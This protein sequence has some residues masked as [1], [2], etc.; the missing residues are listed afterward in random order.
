MCYLQGYAFCQTCQSRLQTCHERINILNFTAK[1]TTRKHDE[2]N[3]YVYLCSTFYE[4]TMEKKKIIIACDSYKGCLTSR[5]VNEALVGVKSEERRV[6]NSTALV[7][8][9]VALEMSDGGDGMLDAFLSAMGGERVTMHAHDALMRW[10]NAEY[11]IANDTAIIEIAQTVGLA[12][13]EPE[14]RNPMKGT[15]WGVGEQIMHAYRRGIRRFIVG[16]GGSATS[17]CGIGML[18]AMG[19]DWK[20][21]RQD[22]TFILASD[23]T[24]PLCG[25]HGAAYVFA[26]QKG[27]DAE[28]VD[29]LDARAR[30]FAEVCKK[31]FAYDA[32]ELP[33][34]GAAG[35]L[36]YAF[37]QFFHAVFHSGADLLLDAVNFDYL[38]ADAD[39]VITGEGHSD[40]Q[41]LMGKLP[42]RILQRSKKH[43]AEVWLVSGGISDKESLLAAGFDRVIAVTPEDMPLSEAMNPKIAK[44]LLNK[45]GDYEIYHF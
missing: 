14:Q 22:C 24:N 28:M 13:I 44:E 10:I 4:E 16:L 8:S 43:Q 37:M 35:G 21:I 26:P 30:N 15:S 2:L 36:G 45:V 27:A 11:G 19:D 34:A 9:I 32:S 1:I 17:D 40:K 12:L 39:L 6:K 25:P 42:M 20:K 5:E 3:N 23:V 41:T 31:H 7:P 29:K 33:G 38:V 18:K